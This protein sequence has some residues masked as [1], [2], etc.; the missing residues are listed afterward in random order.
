MQ[1][2]VVNVH[3]ELAEAKVGKMHARLGVILALLTLFD[4]YDTF[5]PAYVIH[6]VKGPWA[7]T[8]QQAGMLVSSGLIGFLFGAAFH[9][10]VADRFARHE[11]IHHRR[12]LHAARIFARPLDL[13]EQQAVGEHDREEPARV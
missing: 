4:G 7:L 12:R 13:S 2:E 5:N 6:Y 1:A 3:E 9:G 11:K 10:A 8:L